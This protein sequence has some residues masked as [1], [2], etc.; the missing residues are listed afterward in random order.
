MVRSLAILASG[1]CFTSQGEAHGDD[2]FLP[3]VGG[4]SARIDRP[5]HQFD[6]V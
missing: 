1:S 4:E 5:Y 2:V 6:V 3:I